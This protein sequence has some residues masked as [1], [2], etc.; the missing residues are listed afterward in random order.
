MDSDASAGAPKNMDAVLI[1]LANYRKAEQ[2]PLSEDRAALEFAERHRDLLRFDH[3]AGKWFKWT[4][5]RWQLDDTMLA[6]AWA[7]DLARELAREVA[8]NSTVTGKAAFAANIERFARADQTLAATSET[9]DVDPWL[10]GTPSWTVNLRTGISRVPAPADFITKIAAVAPAETAICPTW[11]RFLHEATG[12]D[13]EL[14]SYLQ[15]FCGYLL[16][17][18][19]REHALLF[20]YG[21]GGNGKSVFLNV[22]SAILGDYA[23]VAPMEAFTNSLS[24]RHPT[25]LAMLRGSRLVSATETEEGRAWAESR[26]KQLTG[27]DPISARFMRQDFLTYRPAFKLVF[28]GNHKPG[29]RNVDDATRRRFNI[30]PFV[31]KPLRP[32]QHLEQKLRA[33]FP[34]IMRWMI[35]G[36]IAWQQHGLQPPKVVADATDEYFTEQDTIR[37]WAE[38]CCDMGHRTYTDTAANLFKSWTA[39]ALSSGEKPGSKKWFCQSLDEL[40]CRPVRNNHSR[41]FNG[42]RLKVTAAR[43]E[44]EADRAWP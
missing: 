40:G 32:D 38:E 3:H 22:V 41:G 39:Y 18:V 21:P 19:T 27:G 26:I 11:L 33:E 6:F 17:G 43:H 16:T 15:R 9:W 8:P 10:L 31:H 36:C 1:E 4:G 29:L 42:I 28:V 30:V 5:I 37:L 20:I 44:T 24:D 7:R 12:G 14:I 23:Q 34:G 13:E 25:D 2:L 35:D